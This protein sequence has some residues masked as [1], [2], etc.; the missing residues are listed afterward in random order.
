[1][2]RSMQEQSEALNRPIVQILVFVQTGTTALRL[3]IKN[4]GRASA[5]NLKL[6]IDRDVYQFDNQNEDANLK[7]KNAFKNTIACFPPNA[8]IEFDLGIGHQLLNGKLS[9]FMINAKYSFVNKDYDEDT[10]IDLT[11]LVGSNPPHNSIYNGLYEI[12]KE[13]IELKNTIKNH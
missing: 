10:M 3:Q 4:V 1:M 13:L 7:S 12:K 8:I 9:E 5:I 11:S 2:A 6:S